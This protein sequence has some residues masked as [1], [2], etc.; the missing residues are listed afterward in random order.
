M[1]YGN[2]EPG[3][4]FLQLAGQN[5]AT[6]AGTGTAYGDLLFYDRVTGNTWK[7]ATSGSLRPF[8]FNGVTTILTQS[9]NELTNVVTSTRGTADADTVMSVVVRGRIETIA[10]GVIP[11]G[12]YVMPGA[13]NPL[14][15]KV[16]DG[17]SANAIVG[18]YVI[19]VTQF[20]NPKDVQPSTADG[21][22]IKIDIEAN[23]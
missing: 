10:E 2:T 18:R 12:A 4:G 5:K 19:N 9:R 3:Y 16:W 1:A 15:V 21:D 8:G 17:V 6:G 20:H 22:A 11:P 7:K 14:H 23:S 13:T